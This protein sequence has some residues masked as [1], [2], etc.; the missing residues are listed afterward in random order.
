MAWRL[1]ER[2]NALIWT[3]GRYNG[4][5]GGP[6]CWLATISPHKLR[7][8]NPEGLF[9]KTFSNTISRRPLCHRPIP[10]NRF[11]E[12]SFRMPLSQG[13]FL[14]TPFDNP[15]SKAGFRKCFSKAR[16]KHP[17]E[18]PCQR[19]FPERPFP[20]RDPVS[21]L[22]PLF[23]DLIASILFKDFSCSWFVKVL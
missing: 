5:K 17:F 3:W 21:F 1:E 14:K 18:G 9:A 16:G 2:E 7:L 4:P 20:V 10:E 12:T 6:K 11:R 13:F 22:R 8:Q 19:A 23:G 15:L